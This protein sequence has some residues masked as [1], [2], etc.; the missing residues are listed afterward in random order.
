MFQSVTISKILFS[1]QIWEGSL[2][3]FL[4]T[5]MLLKSF[6]FFIPAA[7]S[8]DLALAL[9]LAHWGEPVLGQQWRRRIRGRRPDNFSIHLIV[10]SSQHD[11]VILFEG[12]SQNSQ[13]FQKPNLDTKLIIK[14]SFSNFKSFVIYLFV[15]S[16]PPLHSG[17]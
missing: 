8:I 15:P 7:A 10:R 4:N 13:C 12:N 1:A 9:W 6:L 11:F 2:T 5:E 17:T 16:F 3:F 14:L